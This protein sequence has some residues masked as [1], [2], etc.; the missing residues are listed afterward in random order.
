MPCGVASGGVKAEI[1]FRAMMRN[2]LTLSGSTLRGRDDETKAAIAFELAE[3]VRA[4]RGPALCCVLVCT[5]KT[6]TKGRSVFKSLD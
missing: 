5:H 6:F 3:F 2:R 1:N 4:A